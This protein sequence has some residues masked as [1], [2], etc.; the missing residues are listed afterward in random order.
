[1]RNTPNE[2]NSACSLATQKRGVILSMYISNGYTY[3]MGQ[4]SASIDV[5]V[6]GTGVHGKA[7]ALDFIFMQLF[8]HEYL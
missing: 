7:D 4:G 8:N 5:H 2:K 6:V 1:M 3:V